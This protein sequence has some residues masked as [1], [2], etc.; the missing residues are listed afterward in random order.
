MFNSKIVFVFTAFLISSSSV[1]A[2]PQD[3]EDSNFKIKAPASRETAPVPDF[4]QMRGVDLSALP[5]DVNLSIFSYLD[6]IGRIKISQ[7]CAR[8]GNLT[9]RQ[10][11]F[12]KV[13]HLYGGSD[14]QSLI[15]AINA[16]DETAVQVLVNNN[17]QIIDRSLIGLIGMIYGQDLTLLGMHVPLPITASINPEKRVRILKNMLLKAPME[18][19]PKYHLG[20]SFL[21]YLALYKGDL[22]RILIDRLSK[23]EIYLLGEDGGSALHAMARAG[24][25][26]LIRY[27]IEKGKFSPKEILRKNKVDKEL[28]GQTTYQAGGWTREVEEMHQRGDFAQSPLDLARRMNH[29][30]IV[31]LFESI[32]K[33]SAPSLRPPSSH[34]ETRSDLWH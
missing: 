29:P 4:E 21:S 19:L 20:E 23:R 34:S 32:L 28:L 22:A 3:G 26:D 18:N 15:R 1:F 17:P 9:A 25:L 8:F 2:A 24:K 30:E 16:D 33:D 5:D 31:E 7:T 10:R 27:M 6:A 14:T 13:S 11:E 12:D